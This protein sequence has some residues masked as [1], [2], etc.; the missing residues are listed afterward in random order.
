MPPIKAERHNKARRAINGDNNNNKPVKREASTATTESNTEGEIRI[1]EQ[2]FVFGTVWHAGRSLLTSVNCRN[3]SDIIAIRVGPTEEV[4]RLHTEFLRRIPYFQRCYDHCHHGFG[5]SY[6]DL[7]D[8]EPSIF[9]R[10]LHY[11][12]FDK[13]SDPSSIRCS[14]Q[15]E[16]EIVTIM[17]TYLLVTKLQMEDFAKRIMD[18]V[19]C[20]HSKYMGASIRELHLVT[21]REV[22]GGPLRRLLLRTLAEAIVDEGFAA[23]FEGQAEVQAFI[24]GDAAMAMGLAKAIVDHAGLPDMSVDKNTPQ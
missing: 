21:S 15:Q 18:I 22:P 17:M 11:V 19:H 10:V 9:E 16:N 14:F 6:M 7:T 1:T 13:L 2:G 23:Y 8:E 20:H 4:F 3:F 5:P 12:Y 24:A